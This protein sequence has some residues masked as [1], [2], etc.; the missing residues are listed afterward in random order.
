MAATLG[1]L[2]TVLDM[3]DVS[4]SVM[5]WTLE[6]TWVADLERMPPEQEGGIPQNSNA[7]RT[8]SIKDPDALGVLREFLKRNDGVNVARKTI[9]DRVTKIAEKTDSR[10]KVTPHVLRHTYGTMIARKGA[11]PQ[12]IRQMMGHADLSN[13]NTYLQPSG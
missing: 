12:Y 2:P 5:V 8:I 9:H 10:K 13:A 6:V 3:A 7:V 11:S 4:D 1:E